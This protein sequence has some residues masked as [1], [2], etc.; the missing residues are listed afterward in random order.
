MDF[1][2]DAETQAY[3]DFADAVEKA[4]HESEV[5]DIATIKR[6]SEKNWQAAAWRLERKFPKKWG[7]HDYVQQELS[8]PE[9]GPVHVHQT[10]IPIPTE[11]IDKA[12]KEKVRREVKRE[13]A[14]S[15]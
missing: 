13:L 12:Y 9:G 14:A 2:P 11:A 5:S 4:V 3:M 1:E 10:A 6:A 15:K 8:G 7:R